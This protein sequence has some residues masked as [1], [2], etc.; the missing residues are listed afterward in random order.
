MAL[1]STF[2]LACNIDC[3]RV[4]ATTMTLPHRGLYSTETGEGNQL[5]RCERPIFSRSIRQRFFLQN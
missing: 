4:A 3:I 5:W 2:F 1:W